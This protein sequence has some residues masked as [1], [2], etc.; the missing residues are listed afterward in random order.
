MKAGSRLAFPA[1]GL[2]GD[3]V[4]NAS[5]TG[6]EWRGDVVV[7]GLSL[8][9]GAVT[10]KVEYSNTRASLGGGSVGVVPFRN[11][12]AS[13][14]PAG[15]SLV[16]SFTA[17]SPVRYTHYGQIGQ[18]TSGMPVLENAV[19]LERR[20]I[21]T[22]DIEANWVQVDPLI[23]DTITLASALP[24]SDDRGLEITF[25]QDLPARFAYRIRSSAAA[26]SPDTLRNLVNGGVQGDVDDDR[27]YTFTVGTQLVSNCS[28]DFDNDNDV[29]LDDHS[30]L[31]AQFGTG[32]YPIDPLD[33]DLF[34]TADL[35]GDN[36]V[37]L[38]DFSIFI[39][40]FG[41]VAADCDP[42]SAAPAMMAMGGGGFSL[43][44]AA[45]PTA[46]SAIDRVAQDLGFTCAQHLCTSMESYELDT[47]L[48]TLNVVQSALQTGNYD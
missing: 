23:I 32:I 21:G 36:E 25:S 8:D 33:P 15:G 7:G 5:N 17:G 45:A 40:Q 20:N 24:V 10:S 30:I 26:A 46:G 29:D 11:H 48:L 34:L 38:D 28:A 39:A 1:G 22:A 9:T 12:D 13:C 35:D 44:A 4:I 42:A 47:Q 18:A 19:V 2:V 27:S 6:S 3:I 16:A 41:N 31:L 43:N 14:S 37:D